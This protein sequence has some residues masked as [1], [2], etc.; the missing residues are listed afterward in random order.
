MN[1]DQEVHSDPRIEAALAELRKMIKEKCPDAI[2]EVVP[3]H[4]GHECYLDVTVDVDDTDDV[5]DIVADRLVDMRVEE[6]L[7][8]FVMPLR[9]AYRVIE[10]LRREGKLP[11]IAREST[12]KAPLGGD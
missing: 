12:A 8:V 10:Q 4:Y 7:P 6:N 2:F 1:A 3:R 9:P 11:S 5:F